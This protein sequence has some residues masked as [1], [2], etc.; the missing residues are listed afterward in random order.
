[1]T[2]DDAPLIL[3]RS[4]VAELHQLLGQLLGEEAPA[5]SSTAEGDG[6]CTASI[7]SAYTGDVRR[8]VQ[9]AGHYD[10]NRQPEPTVDD[11]PGGWHRSAPD[12]DGDR[13]TWSDWASGATPHQE[14]P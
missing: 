4:T 12:P 13:V 10:E 8:C 14:Q 1:V 2:Q 6:T 7:K 9:P 3:P 11:E 5:Q